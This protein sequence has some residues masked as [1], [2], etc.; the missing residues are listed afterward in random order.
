ME[1]GF[2]RI[3]EVV[4]RRARLVLRWVTVRG[5]G[6]DTTSYLYMRS[7]ADGSQFNWPHRIENKNSKN[8]E[9]LNWY[10]QKKRPGQESVEVESVLWERKRFY[11]IPSWCVTS[12][13]DQLSF[14]PSVDGKWVPAKGSGSAKSLGRYT[15]RTSQTQWYIQPRLSGLRKGEMSTVP[16]FP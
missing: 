9:K 2:C 11:G 15:D 7:K 12:Q 14:L 13:S 6:Y 8:E 1:F 10:A 16:R 5:Y 3:N 4:L